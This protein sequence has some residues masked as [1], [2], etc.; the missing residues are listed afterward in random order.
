MREDC[1]VYEWKTFSYSRISVINWQIDFFQQ[2]STLQLAY[3]FFYYVF[4]IM[5][6]WFN[7]Q[8]LLTWRHDVNNKTSYLKKQ[9]SLF[10]LFTSYSLIEIFKMHFS[11]HLIRNIFNGIFDKCRGRSILLSRRRFCFQKEYLLVVNLRIQGRNH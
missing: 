3:N 10:K 9:Q 2:I 7:F 4:I 11:K 5:N 6:M 8:H 1:S